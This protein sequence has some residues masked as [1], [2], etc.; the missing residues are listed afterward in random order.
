[1]RPADLDAPGPQPTKACD[2]RQGFSGLGSIGLQTVPRRTDNQTPSVILSGGL[3]VGS[4][5]L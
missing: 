5:L 2:H 3:D 4:S 1:M